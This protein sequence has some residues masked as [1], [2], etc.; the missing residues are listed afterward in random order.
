[1][2][3]D[4]AATDV[5]RR[6][7]FSGPAVDPQVADRRVLRGGTPWLRPPPRLALDLSGRGLPLLAALSPPAR[8]TLSKLLDR[9]V[10]AQLV[11]SDCFILGSLY[12]NSYFA[13]GDYHARAIAALPPEALPRR[14][15]GLELTAAGP[16]IRE[17]A[18]ADPV[19]VAERCLFATPHEP[20]HWGLWLTSSLVTLEYFRRRRGR[21]DRLLVHLNHPNMRSML[22]FMGLGA[23]DVLEHDVFRPHRFRCID[24]PRTPAMDFHVY[25]EEQAL[26][27]D[28]AT[29]HGEGTPARRIFVARRGRSQ[30]GYRPL[31]N[32]AELVVA[33]EAAGFLV[34]EP[35]LLSTAAQMGLFAQAEVVV[36]L[37]GGSMFNAVFCRPG[38]RLV[39]IEATPIFLD[40]HC[41]LFASLGLDYGIVLGAQENTVDGTAGPHGPWRLDVQA[42]LPA[43]T[44]F[45]RA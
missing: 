18:L 15:S 1:M 9:F 12:Q 10:D 34:V 33:M 30:G 21:Y 22:G 2:T 16:A 17:A 41:N 40:R 27:R 28:L 3:P 35:E 39:S 37:G 19:E 29:R 20:H 44:R 11:W 6:L 24:V 23:D 7:R 4:A 26:F 38:T 45:L 14:L 13:S 43:L 32:E 8:P 25:P 31:V 36:G 42:M 5:V